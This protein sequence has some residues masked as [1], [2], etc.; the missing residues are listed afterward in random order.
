MN[1]Y[2]MMD[3]SA[4]IKSLKKINELIKTPNMVLFLKYFHFYVLFLTCWDLAFL[5][6]KA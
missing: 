2:E 6:I 5:K 3:V 1:H 4:A